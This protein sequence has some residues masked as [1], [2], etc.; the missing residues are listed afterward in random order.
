VD[1]VRYA[2]IP[3][4]SLGTL[5]LECIPLV[6]TPFRREKIFETRARSTVAKAS[7]DA[8]VPMRQLLFREPKRE[9]KSNAADRSSYLIV[10]ISGIHSAERN[11]ADPRRPF[12]CASAPSPR[13]HVA[14][15]HHRCAIRCIL[16]KRSTPT[17]YQE[18]AAGWPQAAF[19]FHSRCPTRPRESPKG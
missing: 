19:Q 8:R 1:L 6:K 13:G 12:K 2:P 15:G 3:Q 9:T 17:P 11:G 7:L 10:T 16:S 14:V 4:R 5:G 18:T